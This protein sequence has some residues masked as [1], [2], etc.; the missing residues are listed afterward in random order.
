MF[1][2]CVETNLDRKDSRNEDGYTLDLTPTGPTW[3]MIQCSRT[4]LSN[5]LFKIKILDLT[6]SPST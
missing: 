2:R 5:G 6:P 4:N 1:Q 3:F